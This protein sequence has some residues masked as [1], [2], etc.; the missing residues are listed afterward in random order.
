MFTKSSWLATS[1]SKKQILKQNNKII[2]GSGEAKYLLNK[3]DKSGLI[4]WETISTDIASILLQLEDSI[5]EPI[6]VRLKKHYEDSESFQ[7]SFCVD[8][9]KM[10]GGIVRNIFLLDKLTSIS[11]TALVFPESVFHNISVL[12][13]TGKKQFQQFY[14][15]RLILGKE[16]IDSKLTKNQILVSGHE[17]PTEK[18]TKV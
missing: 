11:N 7:E 12:K 16:A 3:T 14:K 1:R 13:S 17:D 2:K 8:V 15:D 10:Y 6:N 9:Q 18:K 5:N 4:R